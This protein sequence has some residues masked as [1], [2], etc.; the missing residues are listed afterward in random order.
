MKTSTAIK[1]LYN[2]AEQRSNKAPFYIKIKQTKGCHLIMDALD[3]GTNLI[4]PCA[5]SGIGK[6]AKNMDYTSAI[7][8]LLDAAKIKYLRGNDAPRGGL[9]GNYIVLTHIN[10]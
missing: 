10:K 4:R 3:N 1:N 2:V 7:C 9:T 5:I 6:Y 8:D